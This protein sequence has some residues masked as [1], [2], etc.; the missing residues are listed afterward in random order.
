MQSSLPKLKIIPVAT[1]DLEG[2]LRLQQS[3]LAKN[4]PEAES[5][6]QGF[7]TVGHSFEVL[8]EMNGKY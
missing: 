1:A 2:I 8:K 4:I 3:N 5:R 6:S 7:V